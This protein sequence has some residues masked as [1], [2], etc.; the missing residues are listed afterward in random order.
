MFDVLTYI[1]ILS[2]LIPFIYSIIRIKALNTE[3][4]ALFLYLSL[5]LIAELFSYYLSK[6]HVKNYI[7]QNLYTLVECTIIVFI[8]YLKFESKKVRV[9][10]ISF[11]LS[12]LTLS[13]IYFYIKNGLN[14]SDSVL[15]TC[16]SC[17]LVS[18]A[19]FYFYNEI[20]ELNIPRLYE[21]YFFWINSAF[22]IYFLGAFAF[23]LFNDYIEKLPLAIYYWVY[24]IQLLINICYNILLS[25]G[26]W[27]IKLK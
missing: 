20:K 3:L 2:G 13:I 4:R 18:L 8:Y 25:V 24:S 15:S 6:N 27:K 26:I 22:L 21:Y 12:F 7:V 19:I 14:E 23:F 10:I 11:Y 1:S 9:S 16:E 17:L 5:T